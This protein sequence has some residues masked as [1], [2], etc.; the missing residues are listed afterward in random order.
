MLL[1]RSRMPARRSVGVR[2]LYQTDDD[3]SA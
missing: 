1:L 2:S 3:P